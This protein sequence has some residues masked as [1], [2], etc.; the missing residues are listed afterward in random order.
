MI[1]VD[2][3]GRC[4]FCK[5]EPVRSKRFDAMYCADCDVWLEDGCGDRT[6]WFCN[7]RPLRP[8]GMEQLCAIF[9][10]E[11]ESVDG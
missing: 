4:R 6:C 7:D 3:R 5:R 2:G 8:S 10:M 11:Y 9:V 1:R